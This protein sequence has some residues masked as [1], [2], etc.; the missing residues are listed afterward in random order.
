MKI[1]ILRENVWPKDVKP[2]FRIWAATYSDQNR[3]L[4]KI[5]ILEDTEKNSLLI[6]SLASIGKYKIFEFKDLLDEQFVSVM[7]TEG[8]EIR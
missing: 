4:I 6:F 5:G 2:Y 7:K 3:Y 1:Y 8:Y